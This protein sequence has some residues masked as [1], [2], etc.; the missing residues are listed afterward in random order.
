MYKR[1]IFI[2]RRDLR[3]FDNTALNMALKNSEEVFLCFILDPRQIEK[4]AFKSQHAIDFMIE[5]IID[6][7]KQLQ[8]GHFHIL[9][10]KADEVILDTI[11]RL[12]ADAV[13]VNKDYTP[14]SIRR[15][16]T[17]G[18]ICV[19]L[20]LEFNS[21]HDCLLNPPDS[22][23]KSDGK[24]YSVFT[25]FYNKASLNPV[26]KPKKLQQGKFLDKKFHD[27]DFNKYLQN[28]RKALIGGRENA[29][30]ILRNTKRFANYSKER[31][32]PFLDAT[33]K[34]SAHL[35]FGT[36]SVREAYHTFQ[37]NLGA[38]NPL[39]RQFYWRDFWT[40]I[41]YNYPYIFG[42]SFHKKFDQIKWNQDKNVFK[43]WC[44]GKTGFPFIDAGMREL[45][46]TGFMHNRARMATAS[47]LTKD[48]HMDWRW[49][50]KYFA[51]KLIDYDPSVNNGNWQWAASTGCDA[52]P[53]F[54]VFNPWRQQERFDPNCKYIK[55]WI[56]EL[57][58]IEPKDIHKIK[59]KPV[60]GYPKPMVEHKTE[61]D[62]A[63][64]I[65]RSVN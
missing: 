48:L 53:Y 40:Q 44:E 57:K 10:G 24:P 15:D 35:K 20:G 47:F 25:P 42:E 62:R 58:A 54:R 32:M 56:P 2:F 7:S 5:S 1:S 38:N 43:R 19:S 39:L 63:K 12:G 36:V 55:R 6:L 27:E 17:I 46:E 8:S 31:D 49:G 60:E 3:L 26:S 61:A 16:K 45:N 50:E 4:N 21:Y 65:Y 34:L 33:T 52:Q 30:K 18:Q 23:V 11:K 41:A 14:F 37:K 59:N 28:T 64:A 9:Y 13:F 29:L 22:I 51:Q